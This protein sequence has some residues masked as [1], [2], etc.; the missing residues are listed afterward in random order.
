MSEHVVLIAGSVGC[1][2]FR[3]FLTVLPEFSESVILA[4]SVGSCLR[5]GSNPATR[6]DCFTSMHAAVEQQGPR[7]IHVEEVI[8]VHRLGLVQR[9]D[10]SFPNSRVCASFMSNCVLKQ[11]T[12]VPDSTHRLGNCAQVTEYLQLAKGFIVAV[13][14]FVCFHRNPATRCDCFTCMHAA[15]ECWLTKFDARWGRSDYVDEDAPVGRS[16]YADPTGPM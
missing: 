1:Q 3:S 12:C 15:E 4:S 5:G 6:C 16:D 7:V 14:C 13:Y 11:Q 2:F 8:D 9:A 10:D